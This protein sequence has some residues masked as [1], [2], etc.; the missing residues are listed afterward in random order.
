MWR[1]GLVTQK[2][3]RLLNFTI[4]FTNTPAEFVVARDNAH[5]VMNELIQSDW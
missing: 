2:S 4:N 1:D 3:T 5:A